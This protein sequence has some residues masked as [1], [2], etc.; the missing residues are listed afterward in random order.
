[1]GRLFDI[2]ERGKEKTGFFPQS[3]AQTGT[4][5]NDNAVTRIVKLLPAEIVAGYV[6]LVAGAEAFADK[7]VQFALACI[8][9]ALG[10]VL[11]PLY[12]IAVGKP[13]GD[14]IKWINVLASTVAFFLWAYLLGGAFAMDQMKTFISFPYNKQIGGFA[15]GVF[16]WIMALVPLDRYRS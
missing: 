9:L 5:E 6:P 14:I 13:K 2:T 10:G 12:L 11:T 4:A 3:V 15:V 1:M 8:V 7:D 16:T